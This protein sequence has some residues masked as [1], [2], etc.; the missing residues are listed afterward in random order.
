[1]LKKTKLDASRAKK[2]VIQ[3]IVEGKSPAEVSRQLHVSES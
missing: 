1:M 2:A 3:M